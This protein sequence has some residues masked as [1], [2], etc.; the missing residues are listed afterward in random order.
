MYRV[1]DK[2]LTR[3]GRKQAS[4][5]VRMEWTSF[6][7]LPCRKRNLMTA[8]VSMS[9]KS[10]ASLTCF[11]ASFLPGGAKELSAPRYINGIHNRPFYASCWGWA[12]K[13][14]LRNQ[15]PPCSELYRTI[16]N[17]TE[18]CLPLLLTAPML[19]AFAAYW[20][21]AKQNN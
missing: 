9:L 6:G 7:A 10:R 19:L 17:Y 1:G 18:L 4:V 12:T 11:R 14:D 2:S 15:R 8:R 16:Q 20:K 21:R 3:P 5:S 13:R